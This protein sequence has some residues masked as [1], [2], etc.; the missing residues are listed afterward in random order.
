MGRDRRDG[1]PSGRIA[2]ALFTVF[3]MGVICL[4]LDLAQIN[5]FLSMTDGTNTEA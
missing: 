3:A 1:S 2:F 5:R 4:H